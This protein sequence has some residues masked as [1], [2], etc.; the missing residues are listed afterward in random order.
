MPV[1]E[2]PEPGAGPAPDKVEEKGN[3]TETPLPPPPPMVD[4][5]DAT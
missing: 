1:T 2:P 3:D 4:D 5:D